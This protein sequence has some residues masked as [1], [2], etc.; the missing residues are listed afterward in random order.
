MPPTPWIA[1]EFLI[2][3]LIHI[4]MDL[5]TWVTVYKLNKKYVMHVFDLLKTL[6][7]HYHQMSIKQVVV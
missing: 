7:K 4:L 5:D 2:Y 3:D 6:K 1:P